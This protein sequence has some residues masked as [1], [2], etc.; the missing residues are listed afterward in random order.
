MDLVKGRYCA[1]RMLHMA[2][3][4][5][6]KFKQPCL[7]RESK[8]QLLMYLLDKGELFY[9]FTLKWLQR[10]AKHVFV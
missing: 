9:T 8:R 2:I 6:M 10:G 4:S 3:Y 5:L 7:V 1:M